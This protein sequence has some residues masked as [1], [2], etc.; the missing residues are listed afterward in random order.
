VISFIDGLRWHSW[1]VSELG[2]EVVL[3]VECLCLDAVDHSTLELCPARGLEQSSAQGHVVRQHLAET[4]ECLRNVFAESIKVTNVHHE[5]LSYAR[6]D[7]TISNRFAENSSVLCEAVAVGQLVNLEQFGLNQSHFVIVLCR[8]LNYKRWVVSF[9]YA[10]RHLEIHFA[11]DLDG[12]GLNEV[13]LS[14]LVVL[15]ENQCILRETLELAL[16][17]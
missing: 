2:V 1:W 13:N 8:L 6:R 17:G 11:E 7:D 12:P 3:I 9:K 14:W 16:A 10:W 4:E 15:P 5:G